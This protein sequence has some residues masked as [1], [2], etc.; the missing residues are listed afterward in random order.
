MYYLETISAYLIY[1][2]DDA[3]RIIDYLV[4]TS[5][6]E[7][8]CICPTIDAE[9]LKKLIYSGFL[10][11]SM[12]GQIQTPYGNKDHIFFIPKIHYLRSVLHWENLHITRTV[13]RLL[14][15]Y[16]LTT[17]VPL[18]TIMDLCVETHGS[19]W[20][21]PPLLE[22][23]EN[24]GSE[25][26]N[27]HLSLQAF[28]LYRDNELVAGEFGTRVGKIYTSYSGFYRENSAGTVQMVLTAQYLQDQGFAFWDLGMPLPYKDRLGAINI[29]RDE[30]VEL[31]RRYRDS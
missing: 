20:L 13:R 14:K 21:T 10:I 11:M 12:Q 6:E 19:D 28:G 4:S 15:K 24:L 2:K 25:K 29:T 8:F 31:F 22:M 7:E 1:P 9:Y 27:H 16:R 23:L 17:E 30:F 26:N 3:D 18:R 5:S